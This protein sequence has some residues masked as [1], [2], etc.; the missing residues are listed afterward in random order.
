MN[1]RHLL[2]HACIFAPT[3][4]VLTIANARTGSKWME[5]PHAWLQVNSP[6]I[7]TSEG[8]IMELFFFLS[9]QRSNQSS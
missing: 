7:H 9:F 3:Q 6:E 4:A 5:S 1:A 2:R 8:D